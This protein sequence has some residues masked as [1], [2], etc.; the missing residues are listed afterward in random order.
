MSR[1]AAPSMQGGTFNLRYGRHQDDVAHEVTTLVEKHDLGFLCV[2]E[3]NDYWRTLHRIPGMDYYATTEYRGGA[4]TGILVRSDLDVTGVRYGSFGDGWITV[5]GGKHAPVTFPR[6]T[7]DG[8]LRVGSVHLPTPTHWTDGRLWSPD[9]R[10]D[11]YLAIMQKVRRFFAVPGRRTRLVAGDWNEPPAT[12]GTWSPGW[13]AAAAGAT[14]YPTESRAGHGRIDYPMVKRGVC[15]DVRKDL[16]LR[17]GSDHEP[18]VFE[19]V[20]SRKAA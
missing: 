20:G 15:R 1:A 17:E 18:V 2:Q 19:V 12:M 9:E 13:V 4:E 10:L 8:W 5:R 11:D 6:L 7:I 3:A 16:Q 14:A